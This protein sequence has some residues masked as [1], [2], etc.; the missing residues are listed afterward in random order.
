MQNRLRRALFVAALVAAAALPS[1]GVG[2][3]GNVNGLA[4][5]PLID[6][7]WVCRNLEEEA[8]AAVESAPNQRD[9][10]PEE[11][12]VAVHAFLTEAISCLAAVRVSVEAA[13]GYQSSTDEGGVRS[14]LAYAQGSDQFALKSISKKEQAG[15]V[16]RWIQTATAFKV[17]AQT[18]LAGIATSRKDAAALAANPPLP[19]TC[20]DPDLRS[21]RG[22]CSVTPADLAAGTGDAENASCK[23]KAE[24]GLKDPYGN[25]LSAMK[26]AKPPKNYY[27]AYAGKSAEPGYIFKS[28][29]RQLFGP[30]EVKFQVG[31]FD[32]NATV[33]TG[34]AC[35]EF[36]VQGSDPL[37]F[38]AVCGRRIDGGVQVYAQSHLGAAGNL[39][40]P[41]TK[42]AQVRVVYSGT[43]FTCSAAAG[44]GAPDFVLAPFA[45]FDLTQGST[46]LVAGIGGSGLTKG[47]EIG[48]DEIYFT[49]Q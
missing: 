40:I 10:L 4:E 47:A 24:P 20:F 42:I 25:Y 12:A 15:D 32:P 16:A 39:F 43:Q 11:T 1:F 36:D 5:Q 34:S 38:F 33:D 46:A 44:K 2:P 26:T 29:G 6:A 35:V 9:F 31:A 8:L 7:I 19:T 21:L 48:L 41:S 45:T 28:L 18:R 49:A 30:F 27:F 37:Q 23:G 17:C 22:L 14:D 3:T 13:G